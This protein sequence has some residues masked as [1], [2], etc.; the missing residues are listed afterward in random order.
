MSCMEDQWEN[1]NKI[2]QQREH[3]P[4]WFS[5]DGLEMRHSFSGFAVSLADCC[6]KLKQICRKISVLFININVWKPCKGS[7]VNITFFI[8]SERKPCTKL[9]HALNCD[10]NHNV[11]NKASFAQYLLLQVMQNYE[12]KYYQILNDCMLNCSQKSKYFCL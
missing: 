10:T 8:K 6:W 9:V 2:D 3:D 1:K 7:F 12:H 4:K 5:F 11:L